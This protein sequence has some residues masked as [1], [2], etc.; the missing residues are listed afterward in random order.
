MLDK[1]KIK[2]LEWL[3]SGLPEE[4]DVVIDEE[5]VNNWVPP[6][7]YCVHVGGD[8]IWV[9]NYKPNPVFGIDVIWQQKIGGEVMPVAATILESSIT[10][11]DYETQWSLK[12]FEHVRHQSMDTVLQKMQEMANREVEITENVKAGSEACLSAYG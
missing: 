5:A 7:R 6:C 3:A 8:D 4:D 10:I 9:E 11:V 1:F 2:I 12:T